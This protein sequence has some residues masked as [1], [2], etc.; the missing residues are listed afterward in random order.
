M[1]GARKNM[2]AKI[3]RQS[4]QGEIRTDEVRVI[5]CKVPIKA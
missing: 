3:E 5:A 1:G 2:N 4:F